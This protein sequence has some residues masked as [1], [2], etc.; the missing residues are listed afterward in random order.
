M[1]RKGK[2][3]LAVLW[4]VTLLL[5][6]VGCSNT[7][8][9]G[10]IEDPEI[11]LATTTST[12]D[13]GLLDAVLPVFEDKTG[14]EVKV[15]SEGTGAALELGRRGDVDVLLVHAKEKELELVAEGYF[16]DRHD[17]MYNDF[18]I[19]GPSHDPVG[20]KGTNDAVAAFQAIAA[21]E[22]TYVSRGDKSGTHLREISLWEKAG[23]SPAGNWYLAVGQGMADTLRIAQEKEGYTLTDR[24]TYLALRDTLDLEILVEGD[25]ILF[26]QYGVMAV[27]PERHPQVNYE[28]ATTLINFF[29]SPEAQELIAK[30][31]K[32]GEILF[33]P[34]AR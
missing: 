21:A 17:V 12:Y 8:D 26:N 32:H 10:E 3:W 7:P 9:T 34:N 25:P 5:G 11:L 23:I 28:G 15:L 20:I 6:L 13:S 18:V 19:V 30:Y 4:A 16:C 1:R 29:I 31:K 24:G 2:V 33:T 27:N 14:Y 22:V